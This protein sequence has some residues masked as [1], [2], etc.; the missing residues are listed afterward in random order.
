MS[1]ISLNLPDSLYKRLEELAKRENVSIDQFIS[2]AL[3]EKI[4][5]LLTQEYLEQ[6]A[7]RGDREKLERAM[8]K[9][10][11]TEPEEYDRL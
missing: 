2:S 7:S 11:D 9:A 8:N 10:A 5:A 4:S 6:R 3:A 1:A